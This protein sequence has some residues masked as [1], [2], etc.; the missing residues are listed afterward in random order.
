MFSSLVLIA[1]LFASQAFAG[2]VTGSAGRVNGFHKQKSFYRFDAETGTAVVGLRLKKRL[3]AGPK[4]LPSSTYQTRM[5]TIPGLAYDAGA[6]E[7]RLTAEGK[8]ITCATVTD[9]TGFFGNSFQE[10]HP[11]ENCDVSVNVVNGAYM[12]S[13][14]Y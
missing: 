2:S 3:Y 6:R 8:V 13:I 5:A 4:S 1:S 12:V 7:I 14:E 11:T 9:E 10:I